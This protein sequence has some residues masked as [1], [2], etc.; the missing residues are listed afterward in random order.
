[1]KEKRIE[2]YKILE[3]RKSNYIANNCDFIKGYQVFIEY[4]ENTCGDKKVLR[5]Y[6]YKSISDIPV[7]LDSILKYF[8]K[9][10]CY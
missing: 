10:K 8:L 2:L 9:R 5:K 3:R 4:T 1:M 7:K 6:D